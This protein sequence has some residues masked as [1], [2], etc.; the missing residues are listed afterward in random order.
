MTKK[1]VRLKPDKKAEIG[2]S[3]VN[4]EIV[5]GLDGASM[6]IEKDEIHVTIWVSAIPNLLEDVILGT[7]NRVPQ[8][9]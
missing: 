8:A 4:G 7:D 5:L 3:I 9:K 1:K 6:T 2:I